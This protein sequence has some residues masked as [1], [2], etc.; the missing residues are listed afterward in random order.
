[1]NWGCEWRYARQRWAGILGYF[2]KKQS[3]DIWTKTS[4]GGAPHV[5]GSDGTVSIAKIVSLSLLV[6]KT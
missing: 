4:P 6:L 3:V 1:M 2:E 5:V